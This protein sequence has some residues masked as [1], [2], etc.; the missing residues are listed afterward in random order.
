MRFKIQNAIILIPFVGYLSALVFI[1]FYLYIFKMFD[2][3]LTPG[4]FLTAVT[5]SVIPITISTWVKISI[6]D[7]IKPLIKNVVS[8][9]LS[10]LVYLVLI[11]FNVDYIRLS[12]IPFLLITGLSFALYRIS[13][14]K[15]DIEKFPVVILILVVPFSI[16][17]LL[18]V[19]LLVVLGLSRLWT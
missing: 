13:I 14:E 6:Y 10:V 2:Y 18:M 19:L 7:N 1:T 9:I 11:R 17:I 15:L 3:Q 5:F 16:N 12:A 8:I 4:V